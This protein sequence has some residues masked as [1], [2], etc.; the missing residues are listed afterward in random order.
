MVGEASPGDRPHY[1]VG[2]APSRRRSL[3][4]PAAVEGDGSVPL[5]AVE[6][7]LLRMGGGFCPL[8]MG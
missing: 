3:L 5:E 1:L 2:V 4:A 6:P 7:P 8:E